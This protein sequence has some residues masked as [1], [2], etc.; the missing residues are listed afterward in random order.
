[1]NGTHGYTVLTTKRLLVGVAVVSV[2]FFLLNFCFTVELKGFLPEALVKTLKFVAFLIASYSMLQSIGV[3]AHKEAMLKDATPG[4]ATEE[5][6]VKALEQLRLIARDE[7]RGVHLA[8][9]SFIILLI[10]AF[11]GEI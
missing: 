10:L 7:S 6:R 1:M 3:R 4:Q 5:A 9:L 2:L 8:G 11:F